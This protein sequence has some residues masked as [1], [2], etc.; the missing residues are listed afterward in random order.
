MK[1]A[2]VLKLDLSNWPLPDAYLIELGRLTAL[3]S[4]L[5]SHMD[6]CLGKLAGFDEIMD[7]RAFILLKHSSFQQKLDGLGALCE[8]IAPEYR[9]LAESAKT[10]GQIRTAQRLRNRFIHNGMAINE[11]TGRVEI[12]IGT[13]RGSMRTS[14]EPVTLAELKRAS[15]EIHLAM[16]A[17]HGLV[18][19]HTSPPTWERRQ[20]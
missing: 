10:V 16:L 8:Q 11:D 6:L 1:D 3:W 7:P 20:R 18:T 4:A 13:A 15:M 14:V 17:L 5:E 2:D 9:Q 12:A 19:G